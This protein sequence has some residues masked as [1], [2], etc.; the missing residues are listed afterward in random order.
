MIANK[1]IMIAFNIMLFDNTEIYLADRNSNIANNYII[2]AISKIL[3]IIYNISFV[4]SK[5]S[6]EYSNSDQ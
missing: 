1:K 4:I 3:T 2:I 5:I 6:S